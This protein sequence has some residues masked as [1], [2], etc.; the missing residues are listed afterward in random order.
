MNIKEYRL[1]QIPE[2][3]KIQDD[4]L[5]LHVLPP[6]L[7]TFSYAVTDT[8]GNISE[9]GRG[10]A[11]S[12]TRNAYNMM[13]LNVAMSAVARL[14]TSSFGDGYIS[15]KGST[16]GFAVITN[17]SRASPNGNNAIVYIGTGTTETLDDYTLPAYSCTTMVTSSFNSTTRKL[18]TTFAGAYAN[19]TGSTI[20]I[21]EA[22]MSIV[23]NTN[24]ALMVH[25]IFD[26]VELPNGKTMTFTYEIEVAYPNP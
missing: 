18:I 15:I 10:K 22:G 20:N 2:C 9:S 14:S 11:N 21:S 17:I 24:P 12:F 1:D 6:P 16:G 7:I 4:C 25:D 3:R 13:A 19:S 8:D 23:I 26:A 5:R